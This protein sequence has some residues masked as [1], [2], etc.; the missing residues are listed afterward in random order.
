MEGDEIVCPE[1]G[2]FHSTDGTGEALTQHIN[3]NHF[4]QID[5]WK[6][7]VAVMSTSG[8]SVLK[9]PYNL[10]VMQN[11]SSE[12]DLCCGISFIGQ[13]GT[14]K[15]M[16]SKETITKGIGKGPR[17]ADIESIAT[18]TEG[19]HCFQ[20]RNVSSLGRPYNTPNN[21]DTNLILQC[22]DFEGYGGT[23]PT[24]T[25]VKGMRKI[26]NVIQTTLSQSENER[27][28]STREY[29]SRAA[30]VLSN[31]VVYLPVSILNADGTNLEIVNY[32]R[33]VLEATAEEAMKGLDCLPVKPSLII[34]FNKQPNEIFEKNIV[35]R[36]QNELLEKFKD[37]APKFFSSVEV[38][39]I[40]LKKKQIDIAPTDNQL[41]PLIEQLKSFG[42]SENVNEKARQLWEQSVV[43]V[44]NDIIN[45][46]YRY[47]L[48][49]FEDVVKK[50][51]FEQL[52]KRKKYNLAL[53]QFDY[54]KMVNSYLDHYCDEHINILHF[55]KNVVSTSYAV[56]HSI[57]FHVSLF[58]RVYLY[59][60]HPS[61]DSPQLRSRLY[62]ET[63][64]K[65]M[66]LSA[67]CQAI[68]LKEQAGYLGLSS[69]LD[70]SLNSVTVTKAWVDQS[71]SPVVRGIH[72]YAYCESSCH[73][74]GKDYPCLQ[75]YSSDHT[76]HLNPLIRVN[77]A[78][79]NETLLNQATKFFQGISK[80]WALEWPG[81]TFETSIELE[82]ESLNNEFVRL[83]HEYIKMSDEQ[84]L[85]SQLQFLKKY[86]LGDLAA[87]LEHP[88][89]GCMLC[90][91]TFAKNSCSG[92]VH[93]F[94][95]PC[96]TR[97][98]NNGIKKCPTCNLGSI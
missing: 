51:A 78:S 25:V 13:S 98:K 44:A 75:K 70:E 93:A 5:E 96:Y 95:E 31:I 60:I 69:G 80:S 49:N 52:E 56:N 3:D 43:S 76:I 33:S 1:C 6:S 35:G 79:K 88:W 28:Q 57:A 97:M 85:E 61:K 34:V 64:N 8:N 82:G 46:N 21:S 11:S 67:M 59:Y 81:E 83:V 74:H 14:G 30:Y 22:K 65:I 48:L 7:T 4:Q 41:Q 15:S 92:C 26:G 23:I 17:V 50:L 16:L 90:F 71:W 84:F 73:S 36:I 86:N 72:P 47:A 94:C 32:D 91:G 40:P 66:I 42:V 55:H 24:N 2:I 29:H 18:T 77:R 54:F 9:V 37:L 89:S 38:I 87:P 12:V 45:D 53:T 68:R 39:I 58:G 63:R 27:N 19:I 10:K 62:K 20:G